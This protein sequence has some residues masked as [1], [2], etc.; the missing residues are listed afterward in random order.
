MIEPKFIT[1]TISLTDNLGIFEISPLPYG[2]G[3]TFG[4]SL[5]RILLSSIEGLAITY[6]KINKVSHQFDTIEGI[7]ESVLEILLN[8]KLIRFKADGKGPFNASLSVSGSG[9]ITADSFKGD[10]VMVANK[11]QYIA[12]I[13]NPKSKIDISVIIDKGYGFEP[14]EQKEAKEYGFIPLDSIFSPVVKVTFKVEETRVGRESNYDKLTLEVQTDG[15]ISP[16]DALAHAAHLLS[17][18]FGA[19]FAKSEKDIDDHNSYQ[20]RINQQMDS[21]ALETIIDELDLPTRVINALLREEIETVGDLLSRGRESLVDLKGVGR[22][23][24]DLIEKELIKLGVSFNND[25]ETQD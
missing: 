2:Y 8:L 16:K 17:S 5:R 19:I 3:H 11:N 25:N 1:K 7:K 9:K 21:K 12:E 4:N 18:F 15:S 23:S 20:T 6:V 10:G 13:T 22:K 24:I 14:S